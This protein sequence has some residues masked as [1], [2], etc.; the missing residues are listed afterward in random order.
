MSD[1]GETY[2]FVIGSR[3]LIPQITQYVAALIGAGYEAES[4]F[5]LIKGKRTELSIK[6]VINKHLAWIA[7]E[8]TWGEDLEVHVIWDGCSVGTYGDI[9]AAL[10]LGCKVVII[11]APKPLVG[12]GI[13]WN[14]AIRLVAELR[15]KSAKARLRY[16]PQIEAAGLEVLG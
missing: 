15:K 12:P 14:I 13:V 10:A 16:L 6:A 4:V 3:T 9:C 1:M 7:N 8:M 11:S 2:I 5:D